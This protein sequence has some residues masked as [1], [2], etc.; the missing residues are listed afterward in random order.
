[1]DIVVVIIGRMFVWLIYGAVPGILI[2]TVLFTLM[3]LEID[4]IPKI[5]LIAWFM[6]I[7]AIL[8]EGILAA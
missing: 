2:F 6:L 7:G 4:S 3:K 1:M 5:H 8:T